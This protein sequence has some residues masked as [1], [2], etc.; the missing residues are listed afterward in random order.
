MR[1][2]TGGPLDLTLFAISIDPLQ[3]VG[4]E[5]RPALANQLPAILKTVRDELFPPRARSGIRRQLC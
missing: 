3:G 4:A 5:L 2:I 1:L